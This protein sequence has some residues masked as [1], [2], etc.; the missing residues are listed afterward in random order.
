MELQ[1]FIYDEIKGTLFQIA[2]FSPQPICSNF[3]PSLLNPYI[4][5][6]NQ[7]NVVNCTVVKKLWSILVFYRICGELTIKT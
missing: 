2:G 1:Y 7:Q 3:T 4:T 6:P 5:M